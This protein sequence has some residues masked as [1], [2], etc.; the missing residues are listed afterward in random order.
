MAE[1][2]SLTKKVTHLY[3]LR[4]M[5]L[6]EDEITKIFNESLEIRLEATNQQLKKW[7]NWLRPVIK[8]VKEL[9]QTTSIPIW[10][11]YMA[12]KPAKTKV[13]RHVTTRKH[14]LPKKVLNNPLTNV[15]RRLQQYRSRKPR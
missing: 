1:Y 9:A 13:T 15:V 7:I 6:P 2:D 4:E 8:K 12:D 5:V 11:H 14:G 3:P 10:R